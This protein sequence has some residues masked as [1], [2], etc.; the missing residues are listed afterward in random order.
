MTTNETIRAMRE[1]VER[2][3]RAYVARIA[4]EEIRRATYQ[5]NRT[6]AER[7]YRK[8]ERRMEGK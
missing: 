5:R 1:R 2:P 3:I 8:I 6:A 7:A 4:R